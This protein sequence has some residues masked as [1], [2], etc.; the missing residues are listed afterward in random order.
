MTEIRSLL[1]VAGV[2]LSPHYDTLHPI[3]NPSLLHHSRLG[4][5][6]D[7]S[8]QAAVANVCSYR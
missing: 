3:F 5:I 6:I 2:C 8:D 4:S 1:V 7:L